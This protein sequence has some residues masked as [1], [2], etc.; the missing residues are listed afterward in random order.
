MTYTVLVAEDEEFIRELAVETLKDAGF[1]V[2]EAKHAEEALTHLRAQGTMIH[3]LFTDIHMPGGMDGLGLAQQTKK[4]W[5]AIAIIL[6]SGR[7]APA[8]SEI[9]NGSR[10]LSKPYDAFAV[11]ISA[12]E[13]I[14]AE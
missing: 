1:Q 5:P 14:D 4:A 9:P 6:T 8:K 11:T 2:L 3:L 12:R 7:P 10:F 13:L